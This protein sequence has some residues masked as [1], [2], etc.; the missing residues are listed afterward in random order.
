M[1]SKYILLFGCW[2]KHGI[3]AELRLSYLAGGGS[4]HKF[5]RKPDSDYGTSAHT[6]QALISANSFDQGI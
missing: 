3:C 1:N 5:L 4:E 6:H 2:L